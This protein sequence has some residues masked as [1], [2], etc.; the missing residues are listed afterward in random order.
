MGPVVVGK[1]TKGDITPLVASCRVDI[2]RLNIGH[3][4]THSNL[5]VLELDLVTHQC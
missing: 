4:N 2:G 1:A 5:L 3:L